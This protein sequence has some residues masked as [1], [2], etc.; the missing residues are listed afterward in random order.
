MGKYFGTDGIRGK[1]Y[2]FLTFELA[3]SL[4]KALSILENETLVIGRDTRESGDMLVDA[5]KQG[6]KVS[7]I[8]VLDIGV[9]PTPKLSFISGE[10]KA[11]GVMVTASHNPY[12]DN[13]IK[14]FNSGTKI[15]LEK[16][17]IIEQ[18][19][20]GLICPPMPNKVGQ[21]LPM[22]SHQKIYESL[23]KG[24]LNP[25]DYRIALDMANGATFETGK[26]MFEKICNHLFT[27]GDT[28]DGKNINVLCGSTHPGQLGWEVANRKLDF[29]FAFD[30]DGDRVL[31]VNKDGKLFD[32]DMLIYVC[33]LYLKEKNKLNHN[34]VVL[35]KMSNLGIIKALKQKDINVVQTDV[36]DKYIIEAMNRFGYV[37]GGENSGHIINTTLLDTG[38]GVLNAIFIVNI[39]KEWGKTIEEICEDIVFY[40]DKMV[41]LRNIDKSLVKHEEV[42]KVVEEVKN[43]LQDD[44]FVIVRASGTEPMIRVS[45]SAKSMDT[46]NECIDLI[47]STLGKLNREEER[48]EQS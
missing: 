22:I 32:G 44:G 41:N 10:M 45:V 26:L 19:I 40:P 11:L 36:G 42:L 38:D 33:A 14:V 9:V 25:T 27:M 5:I 20:D 28:P 23:F 46:V 34:T 18:V 2:E 48:S 30:G 6:A 3:F 21:D 1:A 37:L 29:G 24:L 12:Q 7:G 16:E 13:G 8:D 35:S 31:M 43:R 15:F 47:V 17:E 4:G 39:M